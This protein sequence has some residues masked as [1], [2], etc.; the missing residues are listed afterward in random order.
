MV[1]LYC[2][3]GEIGSAE[4]ARGQLRSEASS[5][6]SGRFY[7]E[8]AAGILDLAKGHATSAALRLEQIGSGT[9]NFQL[10][11]LLARAFVES[12]QYHKANDLYRDLLERHDLWHFSL[13]WTGQWRTTT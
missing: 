7:E 1:E 6:Q 11:M 5:T 4:E 2:R 3:L 8:W 10:G 13:R 12:G 9:G